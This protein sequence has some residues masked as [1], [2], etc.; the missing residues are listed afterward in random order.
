M[1]YRYTCCCASACWYLCLSV[2]LCACR[3]CIFWEKSRIRNNIS[4]MKNG[5]KVEQWAENN[6]NI[7][8]WMFECN[9]CWL[10]LSVLIYIE[11]CFAQQQTPSVC[12]WMH[13]HTMILINDWLLNNKYTTQ[14]LHQTL[15]D[16]IG[17]PSI[18]GIWHPI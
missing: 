13:N 4:K 2:Y 15:V 1:N 6:G 10:V 18:S 5:I 16:G 17:V 9:Q 3:W 11:L 8:M 7:P 12:V 14:R